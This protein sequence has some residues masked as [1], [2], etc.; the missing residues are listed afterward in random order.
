MLASQPYS[1]AETTEWVNLKMTNHS[2]NSNMVNKF[3][4][5]DI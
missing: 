5:L 4:G 1:G 2:E 3:E